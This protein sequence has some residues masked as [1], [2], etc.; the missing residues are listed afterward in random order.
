MQL[1][2]AQLVIIVVV[3][4]VVLCNEN[5]KPHNPH[6]RTAPAH[7]CADSGSHGARVWMLLLCSGMVLVC[8]LCCESPHPVVARTVD[9]TLLLLKLKSKRNAFVCW[10]ATLA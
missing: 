7:V 9:T 2:Q 8:V 3:I 4:S 10:P 1:E 5:G 6:S